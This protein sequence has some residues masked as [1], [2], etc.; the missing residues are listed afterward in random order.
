MTLTRLFSVLILLIAATARA[1]PPV[2]IAKPPTRRGHSATRRG[3][4]SA[5]LMSLIAT[6]L[7]PRCNTG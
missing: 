5:K 7:G 2:R 4:P 3:T 1:A 6:P